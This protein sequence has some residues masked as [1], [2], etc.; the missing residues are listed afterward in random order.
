MLEI[1]SQYK[2]YSGKM[3]KKQTNKLKNLAIFE[4]KRPNT[5]KAMYQFWVSKI[6]I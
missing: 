1:N 5:F 3:K 4:E 6:S 2:N